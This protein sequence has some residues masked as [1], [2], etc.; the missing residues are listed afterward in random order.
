MRSLIIIEVSH[1]ETTDGLEQF[2]AD[3]LSE[4]DWTEGV[5]VNAWTVKVDLPECFVLAE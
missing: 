3:A 5:S 2:I 4:A 1:G